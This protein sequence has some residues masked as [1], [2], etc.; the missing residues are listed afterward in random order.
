MVIHAVYPK[1]NR[2]SGAG[3]NAELVAVAVQENAN[4]DW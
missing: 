4:S 2:S 3:R 1:V